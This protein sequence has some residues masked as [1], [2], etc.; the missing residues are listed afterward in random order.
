[1]DQIHV[2]TRLTLAA[3]Q[4]GQ[5]SSLHGTNSSDSVIFSLFFSPTMISDIIT[6]TMRYARSKNNQNFSVTYTDIYHLLWLIL[7]S[8]YNALPGERDY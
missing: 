8:G 6:K 1:M 7:I 4:I 2:H 3:A 5:R